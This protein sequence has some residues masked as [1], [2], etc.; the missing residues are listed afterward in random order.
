M[1]GLVQTRLKQIPSLTTCIYFSKH[2]ITRD[3]ITEFT[4]HVIWLTI[5]SK[6]WNDNKGM[7]RVID[8][9]AR[10][11]QDIAHQWKITWQMYRLYLNVTLPFK[12][13]VYPSKCRRQCLIQQNCSDNDHEREKLGHLSRYGHVSMQTDRKID[14]VFSTLS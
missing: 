6:S 2:N 3:I 11:S 5:V 1:A 14:W 4:V 13:F 10:I 7:T 12:T 9:R 8:V